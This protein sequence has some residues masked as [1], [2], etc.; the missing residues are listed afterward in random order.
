[1]LGVDDHPVEIEDDG[2]DGHNDT[3]LCPT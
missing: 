2:V 1:V 3:Y